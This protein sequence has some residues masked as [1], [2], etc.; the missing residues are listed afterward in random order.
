MSGADA[1]ELVAM[2]PRNLPSVLNV[3]E[4][5]AHRYLARAFSRG[6]TVCV[7]SKW[8]FIDVKSVQHKNT[9]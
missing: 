5:S 3:R 4:A 9:G 7:L 2:S 6:E 1:D 8:H